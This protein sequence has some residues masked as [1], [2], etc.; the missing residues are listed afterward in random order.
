MVILMN[1][2][3]L[4]FLAFPLLGVI[5]PLILW[6]TNR[7]RVRDVD[8][9]GQSILNFQTSWSILLFSIH[10]AG[11]AL[12]LIMGKVNHAILYAYAISMGVLYPYNLFQIITNINRYRKHGE[13]RYGPAFKFLGA[14]KGKI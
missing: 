12:I 7:N 14:V 10:M 9:V 13:V 5:I 11:L 3:Q 4:T 1:L 2:T 6:L 8:E